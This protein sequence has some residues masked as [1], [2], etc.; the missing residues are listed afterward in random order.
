LGKLDREN[1]TIGQ[2]QINKKDTQPVHHNSFSAGQLGRGKEAM[3]NKR[4]QN[5]KM[6]QNAFGKKKNARKRRIF[7]RKIFG[8]TCFST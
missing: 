2:N 8:T 6:Q 7:H 1:S 3:L 5:L 4:Q